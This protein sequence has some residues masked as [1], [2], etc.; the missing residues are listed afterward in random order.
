MIVIYEIPLDIVVEYLSVISGYPIVSIG[1]GNGTLEYL[2]KENGVSN[3]ILINPAPQSFRKYPENGKYLEPNYNTV[4]DLIK[5]RPKILGKCVLFIPWATHNSEGEYDIEGINILNPIAIISLYEVNGGAGSYS[6]HRWLQNIKCRD[7]R[8]KSVA[9]E[10]PNNYTV[11]RSHSYIKRKL[12]F[13]R[14]NQLILMKRLKRMYKD[15]I[16]LIHPTKPS[17]VIA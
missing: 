11:L 1:C 9:T 2:L 16:L 6:F 17:N 10:G 8:T 4:H 3:L 7:D 15:L 12:G 13:R 14:I 5:D